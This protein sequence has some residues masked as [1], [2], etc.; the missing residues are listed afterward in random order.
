M[1]FPVLRSTVYKA[2]EQAH[3]QGV[4]CISNT[5]TSHFGRKLS[6]KERDSLSTRII[7][8]SSA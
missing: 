8:N 5:I 3:Q 1:C 7:W 4:G 2:K 6:W